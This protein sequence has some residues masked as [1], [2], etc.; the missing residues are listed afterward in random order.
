MRVTHVS[1]AIF[2]ASGLFGGGERY[3][4]ELARAMAEQVPTRLVSF[5]REA[6]NY[7][8]GALEVSLLPIRRHIGGDLNPISEQFPRALRGADVL[9]MHQVK[10]MLTSFAVQTSRRSRTPVF[11][12]DHGGGSRHYGRR[13]GWDRSLTGFLPVSQ[14]SAN[15]FPGFADRTEVIHGGVD[16]DRF[17]RDGSPRSMDVLY[18]GR[19]LPH[20][21]VDVLIRALPDGATLDVFGRAY[22]PSYFA[23]LQQLAAGKDVRFHTGASDAD[24]LAAYRS[25]R[26][27]ALPSVYETPYG[28][29]APFAELLGL[30]LLEAMACGTPTVAS[31]VGGMPEIVADGVTGRVVPPS[32]VEALRDALTEFLGSDKTWASASQAANDRVH[33]HFTWKRVVEKCLR[34]Y[35][36]RPESHG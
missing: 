9:H 30:V 34:A 10:T 26:V 3:P 14:F 29:N 2:G 25:A 17:C 4:L 13:F 11:A 20:K 31:A 15:L 12:T 1:P 8:E 24:I 19:L 36:G 16:V 28:P 5:A 33:E 32:D 21:G 22:S 35:E 23:I 27:F 18:V 6:R 7:S